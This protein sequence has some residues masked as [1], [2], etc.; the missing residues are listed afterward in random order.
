LYY[1]IFILHYSVFIDIDNNK[2]IPYI[3]IEKYTALKKEDNEPI[4]IFNALW[5][6]ACNYEADY[7]Y[8][9]AGLA[10]IVYF[11]EKCEVFEK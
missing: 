1:S 5:D 2:F 4:S 10:I 11:F 7:N 6:F 9:S 8:R 3:F